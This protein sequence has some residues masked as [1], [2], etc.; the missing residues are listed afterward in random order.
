MKK[1][2]ALALLALVFGFASAQPVTI[3]HKYGSTTI[4][5]TPERVVTVGLTEQDALLALGVVPVGTTEWFG[6]YPGAL[7]PWAQAK[8]EELG[9]ET[10]QVVGGAGAVNLEAV[11]ALE[12]DLILALYSGIT[13]EEY[14]QLSQI[15]PTIAQPAGYVD[16]GVPWQ[17]LTRTVGQAVGKFQ[18]A[19]A[20]VEEVEARFTEVREQ[21]PEFVGATSVVA[22]PYQGIYLYGSEDVRGRLLSN[23]GFILPEGLDAITGEAFGGNIS[24]ER[25]DL[26][27]VDVI[28]WLDAKA[29]QGPLGN[30]V[31]QSLRVSEEG[32]EVFLDSDDDPL[33][34]A[35]SFVSVLSLPFLLDG[36]VPMLAAAI[37]GDPNTNAAPTDERE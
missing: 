22:T 29:G 36:L 11:L 2:F 24:P 13:A 15:A 33:G 4:E 35:T 25:T 9:G 31:Y 19:D 7:W 5:V 16:Y 37:D 6:E 23:L 1:L 18:E 12:P 32:R 27:D 30:P 10:P 21:H 3:E 8:L 14:A 34:G 17:E 20:L 26:L 28:I